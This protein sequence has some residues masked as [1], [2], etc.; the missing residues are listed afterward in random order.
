MKAGCCPLQEHPPRKDF[1]RAVS[2]LTGYLVQASGATC[3][4]LYYLT[5][6]DPRGQSV[7]PSAGPAHPPTHFLSLQ[8]TASSCPSPIRRLSA[9]V[10]D[11]SR[12]ALRGSK[13]NNSTFVF[14]FGGV[15]A[16]RQ[17]CGCKLITQ[18]ILKSLRVNNHYNISINIEIVTSA[19]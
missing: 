1:V 6:L 4:T 14:F 5:Q 8:P 16:A 2:L 15:S 11:E 9:Q 17:E 12:V 13:G 3:C 10:G 7:C 18:I 19:H